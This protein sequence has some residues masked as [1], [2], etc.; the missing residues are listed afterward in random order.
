MD[1][2]QKL[3]FGMIDYFS[4]DPKRIQHLVKVHS[5]ARLIGQGEELGEKEL[6]TL[7]AAA[8]VHDIGIRAAEEKYGDCSGRLQEEEGPA[9][10]EKMLRELGFPRE[11]IERVCFLVGHHH[12]Y[13]DVEGLD[14]RILLEADF[15]VNLFEENTQEEAVWAAYEKIF[16]TETGRRI[17][18]AMFE[19]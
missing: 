4:G 11:M 19:V 16:C 2:M 5:F 9:L 3:Y 18:R 13:T 12:T 10:A 7:E 17:C 15:L 8:L 6:Y 14:Y 1:K